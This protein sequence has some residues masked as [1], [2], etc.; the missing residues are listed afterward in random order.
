MA[1]QERSRKYYLKC[2]KQINQKHSEYYLKNKE[3]INIRHKQYN[4]EKYEL[5]KITMKN[6][7]ING[8]AICGYNKCD[9]CLDFHHVNPSDKK[10]MVNIRDLQRKEYKILEELNKCILLCKNCHYEIH[11]KERK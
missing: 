3:E 11:A 4:K 5:N 1:Q 10:F 9:K 8:C 7:K 2:K 6:L